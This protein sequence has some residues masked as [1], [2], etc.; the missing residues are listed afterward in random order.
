VQG[1]ASI[2]ILCGRAVIGPVEFSVR[3]PVM[4]D[5]VVKYVLSAVVRPQSISQLLL[6]QRLPSDWIGEVLDGNRRIVART[7]EP[8]RNVGQLASTSLRDALDRAPEGWFYGTAIEGWES[9]APYNRS[10]LRTG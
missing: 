1:Y 3:V 7:I 10:S 8:E 6:A 5:G 2:F 9:Y 4:R